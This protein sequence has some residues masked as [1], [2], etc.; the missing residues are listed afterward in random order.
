MCIIG[1][2]ARWCVK[3]VID[4]CTT[5]PRLTNKDAILNFLEILFLLSISLI[6]KYK[7]VVFFIKSTRVMVLGLCQLCLQ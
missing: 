6:L 5:I 1:M 7:S 3:L 4:W 2:L